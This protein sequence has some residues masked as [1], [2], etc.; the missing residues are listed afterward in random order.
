MDFFSSYSL[1]SLVAI[2]GSVCIL[3][4]GVFGHLNFKLINIKTVQIVSSVLGG[5]FSFV[6]FSSMYRLN[7]EFGALISEVHYLM[8]IFLFALSVLLGFFTRSILPDLLQI[9][10]LVVF[11]FSAV[12]I[13][14]S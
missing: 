4:L 12:L 2:I 13:L 11:G 6:Y 1:F 14:A 8:T 5:I 9:I 3:Y 7:V 10:G